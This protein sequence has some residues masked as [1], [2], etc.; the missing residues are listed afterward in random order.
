MK[1]STFNYSDQDDVEIFVYKWE[2]DTKPKAVVQ[3][4]HGLAEHAKRYERLAEALCNDGYICYADD[5]RGH[6]RTAGDLTEATLAG[7]A[8]VLGPNGWS[9]T[10]NSI[11][12]LSKIIKKE[13]S[14]IPLFLLGHSWGSLLAQDYIQEW[15]NEIKGVVL[16]G[17]VGKIRKL[18]IIAGRLII[19]SELKKLGPTTASEKLDKMNF[20]S[21]NRDWKNEEGATGFEW[22]SR[23]KAEV[24]K[25]VDDPW[26][27]FINPASLWLEFLNG[28]EKI[29]H[30]NNQGKIPK[31]LPIFLIAGTLDPV[32]TKTKTLQTLMKRYREYGIKDVSHKFYE[33]ARHEVFNEINRKEVFS[34]VINWLNSHIS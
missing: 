2:P 6:G 32:G 17:T 23:D 24:K 18:V 16:S 19:K 5:H 34:D 25:Y 1:S 13:N 27:G 22:L 11:H 12:E 21:Y 10:I 14:D 3:I 20:K 30:K 15:G 8:G 33:D 28:L 9:G 4:L 29:F 7:N 31:D 26:C